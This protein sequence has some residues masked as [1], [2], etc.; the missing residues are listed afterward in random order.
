MRTV[1]L[2]GAALF[3]SALIIGA[4]GVGS[5]IWYLSLLGSSAVVSAAGEFGKLALAGVLPPLAAFIVG[6]RSTKVRSRYE[7]FYN[8]VLFALMTSWLSMFITFFVVPQLPVFKFPFLAAELN[9]MWP[10]LLALV[11]AIV[12]GLEYGHK[13]HQKLLHEYLPFKLALTIPLIALIAG[14]AGELIRQLASP[15]PSVYGMIVMVPLILM[16]GLLVISYFLS[17]ERNAGDRL[18]E[19]S[20]CASIGLFATMI[21]SQIP[22][23]GFGIST[24]VIVPSVI[25]I[26]VWLAFLYFYFYRRTDSLK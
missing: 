6:D 25:G 19:A 24:E 26:L 7:H 11:I 4:F 23:F 15:N 10:A 16:V 20:I 3:I 2:F 22:Y 18:T 1:S 21:A 9:A 5:A 13:R 17:T 14:S 12:I 8:G